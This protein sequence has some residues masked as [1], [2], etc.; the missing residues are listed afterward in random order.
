MF[1]GR[2]R[3][4]APVAP[5]A[6]VAPVQQQVLPPRVSPTRQNVVYK[7]CDYIVPEVHPSHTTLVN[8]HLYKHYHSF[9][10][11]QSV[12]N[13]VANQQFVCPPG[14]VGPAAAP[15]RFF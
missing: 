5:M 9:P 14:P 1:F 15:R 8:H 10:H 7:Q 3:P 2:P 4:A 11:T 12:V 13:T 6:P